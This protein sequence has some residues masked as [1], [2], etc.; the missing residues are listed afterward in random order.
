MPENCDYTR[1]RSVGTW[2]GTRGGVCETALRR[3]A[4]CTESKRAAGRR[5]A[6]G[7]AITHRRH[8]LNSLHNTN[9]SFL[10]ACQP[11]VGKLGVFRIR[12]SIRR[13]GRF[14]DCHHTQVAGDL[15]ADPDGGIDLPALP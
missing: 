13:L 2:M 11:W 4:D 10:S 8:M 15:Q 9:I 6:K 12:V 7:C 14:T 5:T 1:R 3:E